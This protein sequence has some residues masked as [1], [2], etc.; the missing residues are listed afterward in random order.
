DGVGRAALNFGHT[1]GHALESVSGFTW[2]H[3]EC[4]A[5]GMI[6]EMEVAVRTGR[7]TEADRARVESVLAQLTLPRRAPEPFDASDVI[8]VATYDKKSRRA[9]PRLVVPDRLGH[10]AWLE[11]RSGSELSTA[12][13]RIEPAGL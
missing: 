9:R 12:L 13:K 11:P 4:V 1:I 6:V 3:G 7:L 8:H 10:V 2:A 5:L